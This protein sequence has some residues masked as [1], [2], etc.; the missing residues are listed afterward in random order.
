MR[1]Y[2][3]L[4]LPLCLSVSAPLWAV[5][6]S[7]NIAITVTSQGGQTVS[8]VTL[9][10]GPP[11]IPNASPCT[12]ATCAW[13]GAGWPSG[14]HVSLVYADMTPISTGYAGTF[15]LS[16]QAGHT[17][18]ASHFSISTSSVNYTD[19]FNISKSRNVGEIKTSGTVAAGDYFITVTATGA[20]GSNTQ[21]VT[22]H[23]AERHECRLRRC[24][25]H[26]RHGSALAE[27]YLY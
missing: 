21:N 7:Q 25:P 14:T 6:T 13:I 12:T 26:Q 24:R 27:L 20:T 11:N 9:T 4:L 22:V 17:G 2:L 5:S 23:A 16:D 3:W 18:D 10:N 15:S 8:E 19:S 1:R